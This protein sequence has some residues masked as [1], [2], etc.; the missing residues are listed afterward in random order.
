MKLRT[1][2]VL[3]IPLMLAAVG[4]QDT[5]QVRTARAS[6]MTDTAPQASDKGYV[7]FYTHA[8]GAAVPIFGVDAQGRSHILGAVGLEE[9]DRY[10]RTRYETDVSEKLRVAVP[11]GNNTFSIERNGPRIRVPVSTG[12]VTPVEIY[13]A[14]LE[15][16]FRMDVYN[17]NVE[18]LPQ[19]TVTE[20]PAKN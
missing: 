7:E 2:S 5:R 18:I 17:A 19:T 8:P 9:G 1:L 16:G 14:R 10:S 20:I 13:Y 3:T 6:G 15:K 12:Q 11:P 4:C